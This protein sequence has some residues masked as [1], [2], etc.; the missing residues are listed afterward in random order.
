MAQEAQ[1]AGRP[2]YANAL[3]RP[4]GIERE[5]GRTARA[6]SVIRSEP[7]WFV[8]TMVRRVAAMLEY[9]PVSIISAEPTVSHSLESIE[10]APVV[11]SRSPLELLSE[12]EMTGNARTLLAQEGE[13]GLRVESD[14]TPNAIQLTTMPTTLRPQFDYVLTVPVKFH[15]GRLSMTVRRVRHPQILASA[16]LPDSLERVPYTN[17]F[18]LAIR[19]PFVSPVDDQVLLVITN[20]EAPTSRAIVEIGRAE[21]RELGPASYLWTRYP[22]MLVKIFQKLFVARYFLPLTILGVVVLAFHRRKVALALVL[23]IPLYYL[24]AH[25]PLHFEYR[26]VLPA[27]YFWFIL[28]ALAIYWLGLMCARVVLLARALRA[29][30]SKS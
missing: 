10:D 3:Y 17:A 12:S 8:G 26:Y 23:T 2:E 14:M 24:L 25:A 18:A 13:F 16:V 30:L 21:L 20:V 15:Q 28:A 11:W 29:T 7:G 4:D 5:R 6:M 22:R 1:W 9:E 19:M 27:Y